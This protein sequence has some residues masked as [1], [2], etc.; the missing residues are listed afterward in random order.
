MIDGAT[1]A[2]TLTLTREDYAAGLRAL[3]GQA[4][5]PKRVLFWISLATLGWFFYSLLSIGRSLLSA[6][7]IVAT[8]A[9]F[10]FL[11]Q[12]AL[13]FLSAHR[14]V[15]KNPDKLGPVKFT[16][17]SEGT[18]YES[19]HGEGGTAWTGFVRIRETSRLFLLYPQTNFAQFLPKRCF[20]SASHVEEFREILKKYYK[21]KLELLD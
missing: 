15:K 5:W 7:L 6:V 19:R 13:P 16:I 3:A 17:S 11:I 10:G 4:S 2:V 20:D 12:Y 1:V 9:C 18:S 21:G 8:F 14:F